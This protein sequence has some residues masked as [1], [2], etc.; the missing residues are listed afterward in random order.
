[1][2]LLAIVAIFREMNLNI[3]LYLTVKMLPYIIAHQ[4]LVCSTAVTCTLC[5]SGNSNFRCPQNVELRN[6]TFS[7]NR[8]TAIQSV[9]KQRNLNQTYRTMPNNFPLF[10]LE[11][12]SIYDNLQCKTILV[13]A[14]KYIT[15]EK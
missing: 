8:L 4:Q 12:Y 11:S 15:V 10:F 6:L 2:F 7:V 14:H 9:R 3:N 1:M 5:C 13:L